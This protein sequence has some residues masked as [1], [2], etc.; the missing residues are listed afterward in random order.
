MRSRWLGALLVLAVLTALALQAGVVARAGFA[1]GDFRA[2]YCAARVASHGADPYQNEPLRTCEAGVLAKS[3]LKKNPGVTIPAPLPAYAIAV[4]VPLAAL[5]FGIAA[6]LWAAILLA[7]WIAAVIALARAAGIAWE[8]ALAALSLGF[9]VLSLPFGEV[10]PLAIAGICGAA[11]YARAG[12]WRASAAC[13][14]LAMIEPHLGLPAAL[15]L[16]LSGAARAGPARAARGGIGRAR[17]GAAR[18]LGK[19]RVLSFRAAG[20][21]VIGGHA[22][23]AV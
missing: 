8:I 18:T 3:F 19:R 6:A 22:R 7:A 5:P 21:R 12:R 4:V 1:M 14:A 17:T 20:A 10:V 16:A 2:F 13:A 11:Y 9:G 23:H 15:A